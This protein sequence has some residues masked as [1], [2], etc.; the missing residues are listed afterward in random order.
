MSINNISL[1]NK[2]NLN[3]IDLPQDVHIHLVKFLSVRDLPSLEA[4]SK[5]SQEVFS[6]P[7]LWKVMSNRLEIRLDPKSST[8]Q[9]KEEIRGTKEKIAEAR[10]NGKELY[11]FIANTLGGFHR[12]VKIPKLPYEARFSEAGLIPPFLRTSG[13]TIGYIDRIVPEDLNA[14]IMR[15]IDVHGRPFIVF[16]YLVRWRAA[17][18]GQYACTL[19]QRYTSS[20]WPLA[21]GGND[22]PSGS[23]ALFGSHVDQD[24]DKHLEFI[25]RLIKREPCGTFSYH[26]EE[27]ERTRNGRS[28]VELY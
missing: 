5:K 23:R 24:Q 16:R 6:N 11:S 13:C 7:D 12:L 17:D 26:G 25:V 27:K 10:E 20:G 18:A 8:E 22:M 21:M 28:V 4:A 14:P 19:F 3:L 1:N 9:I 15:G 2:E